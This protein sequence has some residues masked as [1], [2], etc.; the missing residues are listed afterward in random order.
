MKTR[1]RVEQFTL[2]L[3]AIRCRLSHIMH[4]L[5]YVMCGHES[6]YNSYKMLS[7]SQDCISKSKVLLRCM[8]VTINSLISISLLIS[9]RV[10]VIYPVS[11]IIFVLAMTPFLRKPSFSK[12]SRVHVVKV[13][14]AVDHEAPIELIN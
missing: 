12:I 3:S 2:A 7:I 10:V 5:Y 6:E 14:Q 11:I 9:V 1:L 13:T 8:G 4:T